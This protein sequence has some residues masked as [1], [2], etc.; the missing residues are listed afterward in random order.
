[1]VKLQAIKV[2]SRAAITKWHNLGGQTRELYFLTIL[3]ARNPRPRHQQGWQGW[4]LPEVSLLGLQMVIFS[5]SLSLVPV[6]VLISFL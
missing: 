1:M 3:E 6:C 2:L 4:F 5:L